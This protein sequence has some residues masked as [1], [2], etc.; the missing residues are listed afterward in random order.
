LAVALHPAAHVLQKAVMHLYPL[1]DEM[2]QALAGLESL[3]AGAPWWQI[4]LVVAAMPAVCEELAFR[5]FIFTGLRN[6]GSPWR[7]ICV[8]AIFFGLS[9]GILQ[10]SLIA[11]LIG[12]LLGWLA[13]RT[14]SILPGMV[15]HLVHNSLGVLTARAPDWLAS[16][17]PTLSALVRPAE[18]GGVAFAWPVVLAG[19]LAGVLIIA[20]LSSAASAPNGGNT[21]AQGNA[22]GTGFGVR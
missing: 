5:G 14:G 13:L 4:V 2:Q 16:Q 11:G 8:S 20:W 12:V 22:L 21:T 3:F 10:Q 15:F 6:T 7:A 19:G 1:S 18:P 9:H 17:W